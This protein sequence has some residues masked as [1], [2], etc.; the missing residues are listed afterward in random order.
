MAGMEGFRAMLIPK[1]PHRPPAPYSLSSSTQ[2]RHGEDAG[3]HR[4]S[5]AVAQ[6][7]STPQPP[8]LWP[9]H[10][11][12]GAGGAQGSPR[13]VSHP[14]SLPWQPWQAQRRRFR[15]GRH[16]LKTVPRPQAT[17]QTPTS[18]PMAAKAGKGRGIQGRHGGDPGWAWGCS[19]NASSPKHPSALRRP[20]GQ[21]GGE[22]KAIPKAHRSPGGASVS[23]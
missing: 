3:W 15:I 9:Q 2:G 21:A 20:P 14:Q 17:P 7:Q 6:H 16:G 23:Q 5:T 19:Q 10:L 1:P 8:T 18:C 12:A 22:F 4:R 13:A 11:G